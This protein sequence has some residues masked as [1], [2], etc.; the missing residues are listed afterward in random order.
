MRL[1]S[2]LRSLHSIPHNCRN[3]DDPSNTTSLFVGAVATD[4]LDECID[5]SD[6][7]L[8]C[9]GVCAAAAAAFEPSNEFNETDGNIGSTVV[10]SSVNGSERVR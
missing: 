5:D 1:P 3:M 2:G 10:S 7:T 6:E 8:F 4:E 9:I